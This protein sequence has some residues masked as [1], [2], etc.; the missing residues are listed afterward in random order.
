MRDADLKLLMEWKGFKDLVR[1][2]R[3]TREGKLTRI[4]TRPLVFE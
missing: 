1:C 2:G 4:N 3:T